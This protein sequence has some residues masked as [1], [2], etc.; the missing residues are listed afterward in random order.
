[1][2]AHARVRCILL[3][4]LLPMLELTCPVLLGCKVLVHSTAPRLENGAIGM[5]PAT[6]HVLGGS[7]SAAE[8]AD[9]LG[10]GEEGAGSGSSVV[11]ISG[12][13]SALPQSSTPVIDLAAD[14]LVPGAA[15]V[16]AP[17][18]VA[19]PAPAQSIPGSAQSCSSDFGQL[20]ALVDRPAV[21]HVGTPASASDGSVLELQY[22]HL[23]TCP[24]VL[25]QLSS[26]SGSSLWSQADLEAFLADKGLMAGGA[27][28]ADAS[29]AKVALP[30]CP[31]WPDSSSLASLAQLH[32]LKAA[33]GLRGSQFYLIP[34]FVAGVAGKLQYN[35][36]VYELGVQLASADAGSAPLEAKLHPKFIWA[37]LGLPASALALAKSL[38]KSHP[39]IGAARSLLLKQFGT[40]LAN[41]FGIAHVQLAPNGNVTVLRLT[42]VFDHALYTAWASYHGVAAG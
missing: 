7:A 9:L 27:I 21:E 19:A 35:T 10:G 2:F 38:G 25:S 5:T 26:M 12:A 8:L 1:M 16:P 34:A 41:W 17:A 22:D 39:E 20:P 32:Q 42:H 6:V 36:D 13:G 4:R 30:R 33:G 15:P 40:A 29:P 28:A 18:Q 37:V 23:P 3:H 14:Q 24:K 11:D 31:K